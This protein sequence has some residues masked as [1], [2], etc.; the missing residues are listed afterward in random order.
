MYWGWDGGYGIVC[1]QLFSK[2]MRP[3][4][5][6]GVDAQDDIERIGEDHDHPPMI[7]FKF[8][9]D[10]PI[11]GNNNISNNKTM[12]SN[13]FGGVRMIFRPDYL[14]LVIFWPAIMS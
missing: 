7:Q 6:Q 3:S 2:Q 13:L 1:R 14:K 12:F 8:Q 11:E 5:A 10:D 4:D 9:H